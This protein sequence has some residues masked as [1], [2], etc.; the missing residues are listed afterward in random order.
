L[1]TAFAAQL[2]KRL[3]E[4]D[5]SEMPALLWLDKWLAAQGTTA[6]DIVHE[7]QQHQGG[8]NVT[9][10]NIITSMRL[11]SA[12]DWRELFESVSL[13]DAM[14]RAERDFAA[15]DFATRDLYRRAI[16]EIASRDNSSG[17]MTGLAGAT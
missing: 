7:E 17:R 11:M 13:V 15:L 3:R 1:S 6:D 2:V 8:A 14:M 16:E 4:Q 10:R 12:V 5:P 9:I